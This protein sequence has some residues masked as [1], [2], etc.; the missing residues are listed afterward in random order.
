MSLLTVDEVR[1]QVE[2]GLED[3]ELL[4]VIERAEIELVRQLGPNAEDGNITQTL[5]GDGELL[6]LTRQPA[7][8]VSI[9]EYGS[10]SPDATA[11]VL[12][13]PAYYSDLTLGTLRRIGSD[14]ATRVVVVYAPVDDDDE[15]RAALIDLVRLYLSGSGYASESESYPDGSSYSYNRGSGGDAERGDIFIRL[16]GIRV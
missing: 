6:Y 5:Y 1:A 15:R 11:T 2:T 10:W 7:S 8:I 12:T 3:D 4:S 16:R 9:T 13:S 14:W